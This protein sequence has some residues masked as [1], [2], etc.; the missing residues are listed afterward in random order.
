MST[1]SQ[2]PPAPARNSHQ[3]STKHHRVDGRFAVILEEDFGVPAAIILDALEGEPKKQA[4]SI[5]E[6]A[7]RTNNPAYALRCWSKKYN[8]G[9]CRRPARTITE[10]PARRH[11]SPGDDRA[12][13]GRPSDTPR[14][15]GGSYG[16]DP[17]R[18]RANVEKMAD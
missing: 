3:A 16:L 9:R 4:I 1:T 13:D 7:S 2:A 12:G 17:A 5:C 11:G 6:W 15:R 18:V 14:R 8:R 10:R